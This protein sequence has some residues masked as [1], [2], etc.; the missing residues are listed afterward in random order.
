MAVLKPSNQPMDM[1]I[2]T[3]GNH[4]SSSLMVALL[5]TNLEDKA[6]D[7]EKLAINPE[8]D[9]FTLSDGTTTGYSAHTIKRRRLMLRLL[10]RQQ[11]SIKAARDLSQ[12]YRNTAEDHK[13]D[14]ETAKVAAEAAKVAAETAETNAETAENKHK[15]RKMKPKHG[16]KRQMVRLYLEKGTQPKHTLLAALELQTALVRLKNGLLKLKTAQ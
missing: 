10:Q 8:D 16:H 12:T 4:P 9:Q 15:H 6:A 7:A 3:D 2:T 1:E 5:Q 11:E 14:A 13:D